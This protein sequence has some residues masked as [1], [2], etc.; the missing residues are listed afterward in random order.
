MATDHL[1]SWELSISTWDLKWDPEAALKFA[2]E[3]ENTIK[4]KKFDGNVTDCDIELYNMLLDHGKVRNVVYFK[5]DIK[6]REEWRIVVDFLKLTWQNL[7]V[8][9]APKIVLRKMKYEADDYNIG[10][11]VTGEKRINV[12]DIYGEENRM[13]E[14]KL[15]EIFKR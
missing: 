12:D 4:E 11:L 15:D 5:S 14:K 3:L 13:M 6:G 7:N 8:S 1:P 2:S 9:Q 10:A